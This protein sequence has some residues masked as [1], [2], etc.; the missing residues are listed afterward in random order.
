M[1]YLIIGNSAAG[2]SAA[3]T[4]HRR[5]P[6]A[7]VTIFSDE[8]YP[9]YSRLLLTYFLSG[10]INQ[11]CLFS[12]NQRDF[13]KDQRNVKLSTRI[14]EI[15]PARQI[16]FSDAGKRYSFDR[17]LIATGSKPVIPNVPGKNLEGVYPLRNLDQAKGIA[18]RIRVGESALVSGGG[19][20]G[21][22]AAQALAKS[23]MKA[24]II[25]SSD[26]LLSRNLDR[27]GSRI[28]EVAAQKHGIDFRFQ[29][30]VREIEKNQK[31]KI[32]VSLGSGEKFCV[33]VLIWAKGVVPAIEIVRGS[34]I[35]SSQGLL[36]DLN[37]ETNRK[38][39]FGA[40]DVIEIF[41]DWEKTPSH[42]PVWP[43][44]IEEGATAALNM[45]GHQVPFQQGIGMNVTE[46]F[47]LPV[48]AI[49]NPET[50]A[51]EEVISFS[52]PQREIY[53]KLVVRGGR[54][55]GAV[56]IGDLKNLGII[57]NLIRNRVHVKDDRHLLTRGAAGFFLQ[58]MKGVD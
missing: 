39:I 9:Y 2:L 50:E 22:Q 32:I 46:L 55:T 7:R 41:S 49:G 43:M 25:V 23:G 18:S 37:L 5:E 35:H 51:G 38:G 4:I 10:K 47:G 44:A 28:L 30:E 24:T 54:V 19:L 57:R 31:G 36:V 34:G 53:R 52:D 15:D 11:D 27:R 42:Y 20:V 56:L 48:A 16:I 40:G 1:K 8:P 29:I 58:T 6:A 12:L 33:G 17:L 45:T 13:L 21:L 3:R 14:V 26:R